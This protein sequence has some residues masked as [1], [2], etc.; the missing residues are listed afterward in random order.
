MS[1]PRTTFWAQSAYGMRTKQPI[2]VLHHQDWVLQVSPEEARGI[3]SSILQAAEAAEQDAFL[4]EWIQR[5][6]GVD[7]LGAGRLVVEYR[8]WREKRRTE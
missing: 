5:T 4:M 6:T 7:E 2:V 3:A 1:A 8:D